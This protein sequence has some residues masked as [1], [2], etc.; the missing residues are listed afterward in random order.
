MF[1]INIIYIHLTKRIVDWSVGQST[2]AGKANGLRWDEH[3]AESHESEDPGGSGF[4]PRRVKFATS[5]SQHPH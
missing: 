1:E 2:P 4:L 3:L 5:L